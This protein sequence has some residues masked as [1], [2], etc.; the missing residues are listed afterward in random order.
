MDPDGGPE[1]QEGE[2][3][4]SALSSLPITER[5]PAKTSETSTFPKLS[6]GI[7]IT[8]TTADS[9]RLNPDFAHPAIKPTE[10]TNQMPPPLS[11]GS[12]SRAPSQPTATTLVDRDQQEDEDE[13]SEEESDSDDE[14]DGVEEVGMDDSDDG[15]GEEDVEVCS[16]PHIEKYSI[17]ILGI[18]HLL[19][20]ARSFM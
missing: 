1:S 15:E 7:S 16:R 9:T 12:Q 2:L 3:K 11:A 20:V 14:D 10:N 5:T 4:S 6:P 18:L 17:E 19:Y 13:D 8:A